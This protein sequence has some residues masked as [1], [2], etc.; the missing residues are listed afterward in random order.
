MFINKKKYKNSSLFIKKKNS[1]L[2]SN[3]NINNIINNN[4]Q[5]KQIPNN[6]LIETT[7]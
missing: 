5:I 1:I 7:N 3:K 4:Q 6:N 2:D